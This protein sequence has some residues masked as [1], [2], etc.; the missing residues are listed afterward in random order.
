MNGGKGGGAY[1]CV[2]VCARVYVPQLCV[3]A[4]L[5]CRA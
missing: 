2:H 3:L 5:K 1:V 4:N